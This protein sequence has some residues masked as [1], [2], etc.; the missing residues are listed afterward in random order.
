VVMRATE[1]EP[2]AAGTLGVRL[3]EPGPEW[4]ALVAR[5]HQRSREPI[6]TERPARRLR[7]LV[8][9]DDAARRGAVALYVQSGWDVR[10]ASDPPGTEEAL[11]GPHIDAVI[12]ELALNGGRWAPILRAAQRVQPHARRIVRASLEGH[13][14]PPAGRPQDLIHRVVDLGAGL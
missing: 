10:L 8:V 11:S 4:A 3:H 5:A 13:P 1:P 6:T 12:A 7:V 9:A 2:P 14:A